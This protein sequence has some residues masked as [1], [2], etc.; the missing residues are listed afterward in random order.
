MPLGIRRVREQVV[1]KVIG[2]KQLASGGGASVGGGMVPTMRRGCSLHSATIGE[3][4]PTLIALYVDSR[5]AL[6]AISRPYNPYPCQSFV[7]PS[8]LATSC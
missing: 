8:N 7:V 3:D 1:G 4:A 5:E 2:V 6:I